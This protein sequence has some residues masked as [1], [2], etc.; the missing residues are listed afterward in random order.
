MSDGFLDRLVGSWT[1]TGTM[2]STELKQ[3][4][5]ARWV[6]QGN[7]LQVHCIQDDPPSQEQSL[8]E[9]IYI[10]GYDNETGQYSMHLFDTFGTGYARTVGIGTRNNDSI[11]FLFEY[12]N[13]LFSNT[14]T[15]NHETENWEMLLR[16][17]EET[18]EWKV[19]A[20]KTLSRER[21]FR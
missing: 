6:V 15:W 20:T 4:V 10:L 8:Y 13:G 21:I 1:L 2:G 5:D 7:F 11:E 19:F 3:K 14:F 16:Q 17:Q 18:G 9:A 12:P